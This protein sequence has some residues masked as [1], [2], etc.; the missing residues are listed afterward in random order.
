M[1]D[2]ANP[3]IWQALKKEFDEPYSEEYIRDK[4]AY[5]KK[6]NLWIED[7]MFIVPV[8]FSVEGRK[9]LQH[10]KLLLEDEDGLIAIHPSFEHLLTSLRTAVA[11]EYK[12]DKQQPV[13]M[14]RWIVSCCLCT[15]TRGLSDGQGPRL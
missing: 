12:L 2:A 7:Q 11:T 1:V 6:Y 4:I 13:L 14:I 8:P 9:M 5:C 10:A 15:F 3:E